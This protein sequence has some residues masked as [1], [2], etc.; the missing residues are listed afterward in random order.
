MGT[1]YVL[2]PYALYEFAKQFSK[3][4]FI[5]VDPQLESNRRRI[6]P[7]KLIRYGTLFGPLLLLEA[8]PSH[9]VE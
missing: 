5:L 8:R 3:A 7:W 1:R 6:A 4:I 9:V 2:L